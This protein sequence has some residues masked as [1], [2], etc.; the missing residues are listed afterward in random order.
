MS[1]DWLVDKQMGHLYNEILLNKRK[2]QTI[3][4]WM[5]LKNIIQSEWSKHKGLP[6]C[7]IPFIQNA[8]NR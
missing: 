2:K 5:N 1:I 8:Q 4:T 3:R 6:D 7:L